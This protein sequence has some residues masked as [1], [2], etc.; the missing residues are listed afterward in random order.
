MCGWVLD[1]EGS[2]LFASTALVVVWT[3]MYL[4]GHYDY[5]IGFHEPPLPPYRTCTGLNFFSAITCTALFASV[6]LPGKLAQS[7]CEGLLKV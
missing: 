6:A 2:W 3:A 1:G 4:M 5:L 7:S